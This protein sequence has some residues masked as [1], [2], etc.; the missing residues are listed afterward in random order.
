MI[1]LNFLCVWH[2]LFYHAS[3]LQVFQL[4]QFSFLLVKMV[5][6]Y[7]VNSILLDIQNHFKKISFITIFIIAFHIYYIPIFKIWRFFIYTM[8]FHIFINTFGY[9]LIEWH[10][11]PPI[12]FSTIN[13]ISISV[14]LLVMLILGLKEILRIN[15]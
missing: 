9:L 5:N 1:A 10:I 15:F 11:P 14:K 2:F 12:P 13:N 4:F 6:H 3:W 8:I 7:E